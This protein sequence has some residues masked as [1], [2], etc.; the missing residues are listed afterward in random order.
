ML[1]LTSATLTVEGQFLK[2]KYKA[3]EVKEVSDICDTDTMQSDLW[4]RAKIGLGAVESHRR[5]RLVL[6]GR[7]FCSPDVEGQVRFLNAITTG[8]FCR[9]SATEKEI[10]I[11]SIYSE[12]PL[13]YFL[14]FLRNPFLAP[15]LHAHAW[16]YAYLLLRTSRLLWYPSLDQV[17]LVFINWFVLNGL[18]MFFY[19]WLHSLAPHLHS[20]R[21]ESESEFVKVRCAN[22]EGRLLARLTSGRLALVPAETS[23]GDKIALCKGANTPLVLRHSEGSDTFRLVG[24]CYID[25]AMCGGLFREEDCREIKLT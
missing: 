1:T 20:L 7:R 6:W 24:E 18:T 15:I 19:S 11:R 14:A 25:G 21:S 12:G 4:F 17:R 16:K 5:E 8:A 10:A 2:D 13:Y 3:D 22:M 23:R 9:L